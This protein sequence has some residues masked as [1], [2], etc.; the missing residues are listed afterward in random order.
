MSPKH[1]TPSEEAVV[2]AETALE[3]APEDSLGVVEGIISTDASLGTKMEALDVAEDEGAGIDARAIKR[4]L[5]LLHLDA[6]SRRNN[7]AV[8]PISRFDN[9]MWSRTVY[10][11]PRHD[12]H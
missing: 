6:I 5:F 7:K 8:G 12:D 3:E 9:V 2:L 11:E 1:E 10:P 4:A